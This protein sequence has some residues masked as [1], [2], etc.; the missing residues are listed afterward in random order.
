MPDSLGSVVVP[1]SGS[2]SSPSSL[3]TL[4]WWEWDWDRTCCCL[5]IS[6]SF[7]SSSCYLL[8][9]PRFLRFFFS[10]QEEEERVGMAM[11]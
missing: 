9:F 8:L 10:E 3:S 5:G 6:F 2:L 11:I 4:P 1:G 7:S